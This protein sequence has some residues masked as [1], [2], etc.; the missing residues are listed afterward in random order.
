MK[1]QKFLFATML[2]GVFGVFT[3]CSD[4]LDTVT[5]EPE[6]TNPVAEEVE[7][8]LTFSAGVS[9][10]NISTRSATEEKGVKVEFDKNV[11]TAGKLVVALFNVE[12]VENNDKPS[13]LIALNVISNPELADDETEN[14]YNLPALKFKITPT[15]TVIESG[16][17]KSYAKVAMVVLGN[18]DLF[19]QNTDGT[20]KFTGNKF[21]EFKTYTDLK[22]NVNYGINYYLKDG[23]MTT[24]SLPNLYE[25]SSN[26]HILKVQA[27]AINSVGIDEEDARLL[28]PA[29]QNISFNKVQNDPIYLYRIAAEVELKSLSFED[30]SEN[31]TFERFVLEEVFIMNAPEYVNWF[32]ADATSTDWGKNLNIAFDDYIKGNNFFHTGNHKGF[33]G[34]GSGVIDAVA[35]QFCN[36]E[37]L[38]R[39]RQN[40]TL[41]FSNKGQNIRGDKYNKY[42]DPDDGDYYGSFNTKSKEFD[43]RREYTQEEANSNNYPQ[44]K[45]AVAPSNYGTGGTDKALCLVVKGRYYY[46]TGGVVVGSDESLAKN[47]YASKYYT[48]VVNKEGEVT[49]TS[50]VPS[51]T[52]EV[53][54]NVRYQISLTISGP[55]SDTP[56]D[57]TK[58][59]YVV[60]K[61]RI[62][63]FGLVEQDSKL[64]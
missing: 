32:D 40:L 9:N 18:C 41:F 7:T 30:Y 19:D 24:W 28:V 57:Y 52:N 20:P 4:D 10:G 46:K 14:S 3:A 27:G 12:K 34:D 8:V 48:V 13:R 29:E 49:N 15:E 44:I 56:W 51:H 39:R 58:N 26:V 50:G 11:N 62:V 22:A 54:R 33:G 43:M 31:Q 36:E 37:I 63:P 2:C 17:T 45:F 55:G 59:S 38:R 5:N 23:T 21:D 53:M 60:P 61:V 25:M 6:V 47:P 64:D 1:I 16:E 42:S 35:G